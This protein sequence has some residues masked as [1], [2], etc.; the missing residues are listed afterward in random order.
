[1]TVDEKL[2]RIRR[3]LQGEALQQVEGKIA[4]LR[5]PQE[6][7]NFIDD[8]ISWIDR[9]KS[10]RARVLFE[11]DVERLPGESPNA[12]LLRLYAA[13]GYLVCGRKGETTTTKARRP[14]VRCFGCVYFDPNPCSPATGYGS[15]TLV[16]DHHKRGRWAGTR[17]CCNQF[18]PSTPTGEKE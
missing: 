5:D 13:N 12:F 10:S 17:R 4:Q 18:Q 2:K 8:T 16:Q 14:G 7:Q 9:Q 3:T 1:M 11:K 6:R 15:C